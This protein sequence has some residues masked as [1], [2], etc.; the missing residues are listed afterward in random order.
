MF[1]NTILSSFCSLFCPYNVKL[2]YNSIKHRTYTRH[3]QIA[4][5]TGWKSVSSLLLL[6]LTHVP[7]LQPRGD[8]YIAMR[9]PVEVSDNLLLM[10]KYVPC[11][12]LGNIL[13][14]YNKYKNI[15]L[16]SQKSINETSNS[17]CP[18]ERTQRIITY[19]VQ[20]YYIIVKVNNKAK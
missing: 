16:Y 12:K 9:R 7:N 10:G 20:Y 1:I 18:L 17:I 19:L 2:W 15:E 13:P 11:V 5:H 4:C 8:N 14:T 6:R 3:Q